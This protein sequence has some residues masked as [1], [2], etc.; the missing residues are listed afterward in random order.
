[1][2]GAAELF[3]GETTLPVAIRAFVRV[4]SDLPDRLRAA[5]RAAAATHLTEEPPLD[6]AEGWERLGTADVVAR[7]EAA[8]VYVRSAERKDAHD[9]ARHEIERREAFAALR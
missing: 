2:R 6:L 1:M 3:T 4:D 8:G 9:I 5:I 7:L